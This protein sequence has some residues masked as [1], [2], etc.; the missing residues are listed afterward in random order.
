MS[1]SDLAAR[2][3]RELRDDASRS[4][5]GYKRVRAILGSCPTVAAIAEQGGYRRV[6][7]RHN[8]RWTDEE[9][10]ALVELSEAGAGFR[11]IAEAACAAVRGFIA[12]YGRQPGE[13]TVQLQA[14][15]DI[16]WSWTVGRE[17]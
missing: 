1:G 6:E 2:V 13:W 15:Y 17:L 4:E 3:A 7:A 10:R 9:D 8:V 16:V 5:A 12:A 14:D 11:D